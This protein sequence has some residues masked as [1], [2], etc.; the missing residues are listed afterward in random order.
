MDAPTKTA[1][2]AAPA[3][4]A[5]APAAKPAAPAAPA[6]PAKPAAAQTAPAAEAQAKPAAAPATPAAPAAEPKAAA[7]PAAAPAAVPK[8]GEE[9]AEVDETAVPALGDEPVDEPAEAPADGEAAEAAAEDGAAEDAEAAEAPIEYEFTAPEGQE[10]YRPELVDAYKDVLQKHRVAPEVAQDILETMLPAIRADVDQQVAA[11]IES[12][13]AE[14]RSQLEE[15]HG[16]NLPAVMKLANRALAKSATPELRTFIRESALA[17]QP[18]L[19]DM[20]AWVG[21]RVTN[22]RSVKSTEPPVQLPTDPEAAAAADYDRRS[23]AKRGG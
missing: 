2:P 6:T 8:L 14:W 23:A 13:S 20:L 19:V 5:K 4:A 3:P 7:K 9:V 10:P 11:K 1:A 17:W 18:D 22:D 12:T 16:K 21:Q 15:R